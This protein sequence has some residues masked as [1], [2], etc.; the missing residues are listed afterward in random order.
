M[1]LPAL[2]ALAL[3]ACGDD[4]TTPDA[5]VA[6]DTTSDTAAPDTSAT[7]DTGVAPDTLA[8]VDDDTE[9]PTEVVEDVAPETTTEVVEDVGPDTAE[10]QVIDP[11]GDT[12]GDGIMDLDEVADGTD[13]FDPRSAR[14]WHPE[15]T[16]HPR[17]FVAAD[18]RALIRARAQ[19][20]EGASKAMWDRIVGLANQTPPSQPA[21]GPGVDYDTSVTPAQGRI[22][23]AAATLAWVNED[24]SFGIKALEI[25][26]APFPDPTPL[27]ERS[28]FNAGDHYDLLEAEGLVPMCS[29]WDLIAADEASYDAALFAAAKARLVERI[30]YFRTLCLD[31]GGCR[32]LLRGEPNNHSVKAISAL[33]LCAMVLPDRATAAIDFNE[34]VASL[35]WIFEE[36]QGNTEGGWAESWNYL[37]YSGESHLAF[38]LAWH[39]IADGATW[40]VK[41]T[42]K[43]T[44]RDPKRNTVQ[45]VR[46]FALNPTLVAVYQKALVATLPD[47]RTPPT[48]DANISALHGGALAALFDDGRFLWNWELPAVNR[49]T[50]QV[51]V[52]TFLTLDPAM[53]PIAPDWP[54]DGFFAEAGFSI[55]KSDFGPEAFYVHV[56]HE[57]DRMRLQG[58]AHEHADP[59]SFIVSARGEPLVI[60]PG[61]IDFT[62]HKK[63]KYGLDHNIVL[64]DDLGPEFY[65]DGLVEVAPIG[66]AFLHEH[67]ALGPHTTLIA[68]TKYADV[69]LRRRF[70]RLGQRALV[71]A[72]QIVDD[73]PHTYTWQLNGYASEELAG[74]TF[75]RTEIIDGVDATWARPNATLSMRVLA[76]EGTRTSADR[77]EESVNVQGNRKHRCV[78]LAAPMDQRAGFL[79]LLVPAD[80]A[81][82][83]RSGRAQEG[84]VWV[85]AGTDAAVL[86]LSGATTSVVVDGHQL[87]IAPGLTIVDLSDDSHLNAT[88]VTPPIPDP[89][90]LIPE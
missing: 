30:D 9:A 49:T 20:T 80:G 36:S 5:S 77:L 59:L 54:L 44:W 84:I 22:A 24:P 41:G 71:V 90:P 27:N 83:I 48:D 42:G 46:D 43:P 10:V 66:D 31:S 35:R 73:E 11:D 32:A 70:V 56:Q 25:L 17:L 86:N 74:T 39:H 16:G 1:K 34:A 3:L 65:L 29:A 78:T 45:Q 76:A 15:I 60:D 79:A 62:N 68:S 8:E 67:G 75:T 28:A 26:A 14:A 40:Q 57:H 82:A 61:Y 55:M 88:M 72:D 19:A 51:V 33:A 89:Q 18:D 50:G 4:T 58:G 6:P 69:E 81:V 2:C 7:S 64:V 63:V 87:D 23:E 13:P 47:G 38:L 21:I 12:D 37:S 52:P 53:Q 85:A